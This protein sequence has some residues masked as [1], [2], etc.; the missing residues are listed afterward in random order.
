[1]LSHPIYRYI[2]LLMTLITF[3]DT[4]FLG[5]LPAPRLKE[6]CSKAAG[7]VAERHR[8]RSCPNRHLVRKFFVDGISALVG[9]QAAMNQHWMIHTYIHRHTHIYI[10]IHDMIPC[11]LVAHIVCIY[12]ILLPALQSARLTSTY[13]HTT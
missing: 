4:R 8:R 6:W 2:P 9:Q 11:I 5:C 12:I 13:G 3:V 10:Y 7:I 1:M